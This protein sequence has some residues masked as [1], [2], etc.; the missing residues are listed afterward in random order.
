MTVVIVVEL[1]VV[2]VHEHQVH[3]GTFAQGFLPLHVQ[4]FIEVAAVG[5]T[6]ELIAAGKLGQFAGKLFELSLFF[7]QQVFLCEYGA[8]PG[9]L[10]EPEQIAKSQ[11]TA[12]IIKQAI[13]FQVHSQDKA[14]QP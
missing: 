11:R 5:Q 8:F 10:D 7:F 6:G 12:A 2:D 4:H 13:Q 3:V 1:E 14:D 9:V